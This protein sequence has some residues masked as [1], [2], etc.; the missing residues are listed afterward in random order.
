MRVLTIWLSG[1]SVSNLK[2]LV[3]LFSCG[4]LAAAGKFL[5]CDACTRTQVRKPIQLFH[6]AVG[7]H[8]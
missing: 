2:V 8:G 5:S 6:M 1:N 4:S 3:W 7:Y